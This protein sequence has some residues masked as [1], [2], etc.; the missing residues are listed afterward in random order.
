MAADS[1]LHSLALVMLPCLLA[2]LASDIILKSIRILLEDV[3]NKHASEANMIYF[4]PLKSIE[5]Q[6]IDRAFANLSR[7]EVCLFN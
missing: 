6:S 2:A 7:A 4:L 5:K 3:I 1:H